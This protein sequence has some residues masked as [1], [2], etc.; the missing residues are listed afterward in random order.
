VS[1]RTK[2]FLGICALCSVLTG[3]GASSS[4]N[5]PDQSQAPPDVTGNWYVTAVSSSTGSSIHLD[6]SIV[7]TQQQL[8]ASLWQ[9]NQTDNQN[10]SSSCT[11]GALWVLAGS[12]S[13]ASMPLTTTSANSSG[14]GATLTLSLTAASDGN[15]VSGNYS[16]SGGCSNGDS[17]TVNGVLVPSI[18]ATWTGAIVGS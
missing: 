4:S 6:G 14:N 3:C 16:V 18:T 8:A 13:G 2:R 9:D 11:A 7:D 1:L 5:N 15:S 17:G 10:D 12:Q